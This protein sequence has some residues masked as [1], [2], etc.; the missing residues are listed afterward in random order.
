MS[1]QSEIHAGLKNMVDQ[2]EQ[3]PIGES[4]ERRVV[5]FINDDV[6]N[7]IKRRRQRL[8]EAKK[9]NFRIG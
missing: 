5:T 7:F 3:M 2:M 6:P 4:I 9:I 1:E 8:E